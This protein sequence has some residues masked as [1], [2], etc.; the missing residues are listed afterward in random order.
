M[1]R[2]A[3]VI[4][5]SS[6]TLGIAIRFTIPSTGVRATFHHTIHGGIH[7][8]ILGIRHT[9]VEDTDTFIGARRDRVRRGQ[10]E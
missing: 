2:G 4:V 1:T 8:T 10:L 7:L 5:G 3:G 9:M 6:D